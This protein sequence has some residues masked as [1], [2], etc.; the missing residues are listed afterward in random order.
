MLKLGYV[1]LYI[2]NTRNCLLIEKNNGEK[3]I[4]S[5]ENSEIF[6]RIIKGYMRLRKREREMQGY[7]LLYS[8]TQLYMELG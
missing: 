7:R 3:I 4:I 2:T 5:P 1:N 6:L 8:L